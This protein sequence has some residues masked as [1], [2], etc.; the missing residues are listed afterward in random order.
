MDKDTRYF[1]VSYSHTDKE[2]VQ[3]IIGRLQ[4]V[5]NIKVWTDENLQPGMVW[6]AEIERALLGAFG[7]LVFISEASLNSAFIRDE[8]ATAIAREKRVLPILLEH[9]V[10]LPLTLVRMQYVDF[11]TPDYSVGLERLIHSVNSLLATDKVASSEIEPILNSDEVRQLEAEIV[12][13]VGGKK[14]N[15][16]ANEPPRSIFIVHGHDLVFRDEVVDYLQSL[17]IKPIILSEIKDPKYQ[18]P[19]FHKFHIIAGQAEF[20]IVLISP[21][22]LGTSRVKYHHRKGGKNALKFRARENV[23]LEL[24]YFLAKLGRNKV[25][26]LYIEGVELPSDYR[27][28]LYV[29][30]DRDGAWRA[31]LI[32]ELSAAGIEVDQSSEKASPVMSLRPYIKPS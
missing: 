9:G 18:D 17:G 12:A 20:A 8:L 21:D 32:K 23:I 5:A 11:T 29:P 10:R 15:G 22:D 7:L 13:Q 16:Q 2:K 3:Y 27:G 24:G 28:V 14:S 19:L 1:F 30:Y 6:E 4:Q 31:Q 25:C 26:C